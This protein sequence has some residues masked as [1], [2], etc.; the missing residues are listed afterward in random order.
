MTRTDE[1]WKLL[2]EADSTVPVVMLNLIRFREHALDGYGCDGMTGEQA[3]AEYGR[4]LRALASDFPGTALWV[5]EAK[6]TF[7]GPEDETWDLVLLV[8]YNSVSIFREMLASDAYQAAA[9]A[10]TAAVVDSRLVL[11]HE[12]LDVGDAMARWAS[13]D[14][15]ES[16]QPIVMLNLIRYRETAR[17]G[18]TCDG[19]TGEAAYTEY[20]RR[21]EAMDNHDF[22]GTVIWNGEAKATVIGPPDEHWDRVLLVAYKS[23]DEL[24]RMARSEAY[25]AAGPARTAAVDDSRLVL[26]HQNF[27][28]S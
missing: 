17:V 28:R 25:Q 8:S 2:A 11:T 20:V 19:M 23:V 5:G 7:I 22:P 3:Y 4:R 18:Q 13:S 15:P 16:E 1:Q 24:R 27:P 21:L 10:R 6:T 12:T 9:T 14:G 26:M